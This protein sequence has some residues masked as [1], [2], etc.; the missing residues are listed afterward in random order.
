[1][2]EKNS[3]GGRERSRPQLRWKDDEVENYK[4]FVVN[5]KRLLELSMNMIDTDFTYVG[6]VSHYHTEATMVLGV[7]GHVML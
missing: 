4:K 2:F 7:E 5:F 3:E 6:M 1:M